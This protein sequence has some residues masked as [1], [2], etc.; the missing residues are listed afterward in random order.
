MCSYTTKRAVVGHQYFIN[1]NPL[2]AVVK[3]LSLNVSS[4]LKFSHHAHIIMTSY[5]KFLGLIRINR[6]PSEVFPEY[7]HNCKLVSK[8]NKK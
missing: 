3:Y 6:D 2:N 8:S 1:N 5:Y 7:R 4:F